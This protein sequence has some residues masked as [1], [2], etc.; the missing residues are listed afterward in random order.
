MTQRIKIARDM[1]IL[2]MV[3]IAVMVVAQNMFI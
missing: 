3:I 1:A 2:A